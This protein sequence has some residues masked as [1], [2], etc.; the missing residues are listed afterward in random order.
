MPNPMNN[1][2]DISLTLGSSD[3]VQMVLMDVLGRNVRTVADGSLEAG[4]HAYTLDVS[5]LPP[6]T[7]YL[8]IQT[9]GQTLTKKLVV[10]H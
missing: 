3:R 5:T 7:Y 4:D 1:A 10:E 6:G 8:R 2:A 9:I